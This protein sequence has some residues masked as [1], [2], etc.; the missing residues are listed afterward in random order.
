MHYVKYNPMWKITL[1]LFQQEEYPQTK[2][3][4]D[5]SA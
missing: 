5:V 4:L 2:I 1:P 3:I